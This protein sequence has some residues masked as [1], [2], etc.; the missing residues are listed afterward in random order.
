[1]L[2]RLQPRQQHR[3]D[4]T[5]CQRLEIA[6]VHLTRHNKFSIALTSF[7]LSGEVILEK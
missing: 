2:E 3:I 5:G 4:Q 7:L 1:M 6:P